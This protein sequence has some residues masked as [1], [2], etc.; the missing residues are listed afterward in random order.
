MV[1]FWGGILAY[2]ILQVIA[3]SGSK[4]IMRILALMPLA[5]MIIVFSVTIIGF[6]Q[7]SNLWLILLIFISPIVIIYL[8]ILVIVKQIKS[9]RNSE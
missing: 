6:A 3:L 5:V 2:P 7:E 8:F 1:G 9:V 4:G